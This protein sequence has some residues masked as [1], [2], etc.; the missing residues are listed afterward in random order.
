MELLIHS[1]SRGGKA[2]RLAVADTSRVGEVLDAVC[3]QELGSDGAGRKARVVHQ[4][5]I[6]DESQA[7]M[8]L[9]EAGIVH[10]DSL[11][12]FALTPIP[13]PGA[14]Q[15]W[16]A[17]SSSAIK[18]AILAEAKKHGIEPQVRA[19]R[20]S[21]T[22][23]QPYFP[24]ELAS[25]EQPLLQLLQAFNPRGAASRGGSGAASAG[26]AADPVAAAMQQ[27]ANAFDVPVSDLHGGGRPRRGAGSDEDEDEEEDDDEHEHGPAEIR[28]PEPSAQAVEQLTG[29]GFLEP[30]VRKALVLGRNN[31]D[32]ALDWLLAHSEDADAA[33][34]PTQ[35]QLRQ[36]YGA[37][38]SQTIAESEAV[39]QLCEMGFERP[40][41][42]QH[43]SSNSR[44]HEGQRFHD[45]MNQL[46]ARL[47]P[48]WRHLAE[49][50]E[51]SLLGAAREQG[52]PTDSQHV[53]PSA[54]LAGMARG[55]Q[56]A[57]LFAG[58]PLPPD[59]SE[60]L[61]RAE[62]D[63]GGQ[64]NLVAAAQ[65]MAQM[66]EHMTG[67]GGEGGRGGGSGNSGMDSNSGGRW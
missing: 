55:G 62:H 20:R 22:I 52:L 45:L 51:Q 4:G 13:M 63:Y 36:V 42:A 35:Q 21:H 31:I 11:L 65:Q 27:L 7:S 50:M 49:H 28:P 67:G 57:Q 58:M 64:A 61:Q 3:K 12:V 26:L 14:P 41:D 46:Q 17:P 44:Q 37:P 32:A 33:E 10:G 34:P 23:S 59:F 47:P 5:R 60:A 29:M 43:G 53:D 40:A 8:T 38:S 66:L 24:S 6:L 54:I 2:E 56:G 9:R 16:P 1:G 15:T 30:V 25:L 48:H 18:S 19:N 39:D